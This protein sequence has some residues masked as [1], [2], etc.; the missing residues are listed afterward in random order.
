M[1]NENS[2]IQNINTNKNDDNSS[3][4]NDHDHNDNHKDENHD[5][6][7]DN[8]SEP[9]LSASITSIAPPNYPLRC[10]KYYLIETMRPL[11]EVHW[12]PHVP[13][14]LSEPGS[15]RAPTRHGVAVPAFGGPR[16]PALV[17]VCC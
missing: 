8:S 1:N 13:E 7:N 3:N 16:F 5:N 9:T 15:D 17:L 14:P 4:D 6:A 12:G 2:S 11:V 10:P